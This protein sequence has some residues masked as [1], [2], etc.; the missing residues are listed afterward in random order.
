MLR[1]YPWFGCSVGARANVGFSLYSI[2]QLEL[3][4]ESMQGNVQRSHGRR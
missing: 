1:M 3:E 2:K 4:L